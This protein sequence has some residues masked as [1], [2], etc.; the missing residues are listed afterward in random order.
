MTPLQI[1]LAV[2]MFLQYCIWGVWAP[3]LAK[4]LG[5]L[6]DFRDDKGF[7]INMVYIT[8]AVASMISPIIS[9]QLVDRFFATQKFLAFSHLIGGITLWWASEQTTFQMLVIVMLIHSMFYAP[10]V[11]LTNS[12]AFSHLSNGEKEFGAVRMWGTVGWIVIGLMFSFMVA[13]KLGNLGD[14]LKVG[15]VCSGLMAVY[16]LT[17]PHTPPKASAT[18]PFAF[19][20]AI[21][22]A[23]DRS[24]A[25]LLIVAFLVSTE[26]QFYYVMTPTYFGDEPGPS[27][28]SSQLIKAAELND[29]DAKDDA[30]LV[31]RWLDLNR[32]SKLS[33]AELEGAPD[34]MTELRTIDAALKGRVDGL[35]AEKLEEVVTEQKLGDSTRTPKIIAGYI[36]TA[37]DDPKAADKE[38]TS[39]EL[40][41]FV[42]QLRKVELI[43]ARI[44]GVFDQYATD[45]GGLGLS[46]E[47]IPRV[48]AIGQAAEIIVLLLLPLALLKLGFGI[49]I[50][51]GI[52]AW[53]VRYAL[54]AMNDPTWVVI[55][56]QSLHG[57]GF[58]FFFV[59]TMIYADRIAPTDIRASAQSLIIFVTYGAGMVVSSLI[60]GPVADYF[61]FDWH[62]IFLVPVAITVACTLLFLIFFRE[63]KA[64]VHSAPID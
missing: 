58:G 57:F 3:V 61:D 15:A 7:K 24:F 38:L 42:D 50:A 11:P 4:Y 25:V 29:K 20:G 59:G 27:L 9:G 8:M 6:E 54:F 36:V 53:A 30:T 23:K 5:D 16:C 10:T 45:K 62:K 19:F 51:I 47:N 26:L 22:L 37:A 41:K 48:M 28:T 2:M 35:T 18:N 52:A 33:K 12:L 60:A 34:R 14:C 44:S 43:P 31:M 13:Y 1:R 17:L 49:T 56:S 55:A 40:S 21:K 64:P 63:T 46:D 32:N 39:A